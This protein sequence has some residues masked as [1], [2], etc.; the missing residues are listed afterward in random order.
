MGNN[1]TQPDQ[2]STPKNTSLPRRVPTDNSSELDSALA[3]PPYKGPA[4]NLHHVSGRTIGLLT[5]QVTPF[6]QVLQSYV[7]NYRLLCQT[8]AKFMIS[9]VVVSS[10]YT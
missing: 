2:P 4:E 6:S 7:V 1:S 9:Q 8:M 3:T 10:T 5:H